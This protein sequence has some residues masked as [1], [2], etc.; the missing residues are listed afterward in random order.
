MCWEFWFI[1]AGIFLLV[2]LLSLQLYFL[3]LS[4]GFIVGGLMSF[5]V[6]DVFTLQMIVGMIM[7]IILTI[8]T[9]PITTHFQ[10]TIGFNNTVDQLT[11]ETGMVIRDIPHDGEGIVKVGKETWT[12]RSRVKIKSGQK[13]IVMSR[14]STVL[15]VK[16]ENK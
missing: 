15:Y 4:M 16:E 13:V 12:A 5:I 3:W 2:E 14:K 7:S 11:G 9:K 6:P 1:L 10:T 8:C